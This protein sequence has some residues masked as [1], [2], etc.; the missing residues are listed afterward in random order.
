MKRNFSIGIVLLAMGFLLLPGVRVSSS[1]KPKGI[2]PISA[3]AAQQRIAGHIKPAAAT[4]VVNTLMDTPDILPGDGLCSDASG[5][6][7]LRAAITEANALAGTDQIHFNILPINFPQTIT[8]TSALPV[9]SDIVIIDGTTQPGFSGAPIVEVRGN[10]PGPAL[11]EVSASNCTIRGLILNGKDGDGIRLEGSFNS[12]V[13]NYIGTDISGLM[14]GPGLGGS[15]IFITGSSFNVIGSIAPG[16]ANIIAFTGTGIS[17]ADGAFSSNGNFI[18]GNSMFSNSLLGID[19]DQNLV[20]PNDNCDGD[21][22]SDTDLNYPDL[23]GAQTTGG[24]ISIQGNYNSQSGS[25]EQLDFYVNTVCHPSGFGEGQTY[26]GTTVVVPDV[27]C[28][29]VFS[30]NFPVA[31]AAGKFITAIARDEAN[32]SS[33][34]SACV[35]V[36]GSSCLIVCPPNQIRNT[37]PNQCGAVVTYPPPTTSGSCGA[38]TPACNPA[39]GSFFPRGSTTVSCSAVG[40]TGCSFTINVIDNSPPRITCPENIVAATD[41]ERANAVVGYPFATVSDN[42]PGTAAVCLPPSGAVFPLGASSVVCSAQDAAGNAVLCSFIVTVVDSQTPIIRCPANLAIVPPTGQTSAVVTYPAPSVSDNLPGV[43]VA[44]APVSG[45]TF[46]AGTTTVTCTAVDASGNRA[47][48]S[49]TVAVGGPQL[50]TTIP[51]STP[52][53]PIATASPARKAPKPKNSLCSLFT[54]QNIGFA[55]LVLTYDSITRTGTDVDNKRITD[56]NDTTFFSVSLLNADQSLASLNIGA[57]LTLQPNQS[58]TLCVKF[59]ALIPAL[60]GKTSGLAASSVLPDT[61]TS[62]INFRQNAGANVAIP[63]LA[64]VTT[65]VVLIDPTNPRRP[66]VVSFSRDGD[67]ITTSCA[68]Y[69]SNLDVNHAKY[70]FLNASGQVVAGPFE[71][72]LTEPVRS[73]NLVKGQSF[74]IEQRFTG[75]SSSPD[76]TSVRITVSDGGSSAVASS[77]TAAAPSLSP[78]SIQL[79]RQAGS[80]TLY[81]P[82][83]RLEPRH[84]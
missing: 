49:F 59:A 25:S 78:S 9:I 35:P 16:D 67:N 46:P 29:A 50:K 70:E 38:V 7:S 39:S 61:I 36:I 69:D 33:E 75:A 45:S 1:T 73:Q 51:G 14:P 65:G 81:L 52:A 55:P 28:N 8:L 18:Q 74:S 43:T 30:V 60:A 22:G 53:V 62:N 40:A 6:C 63:V 11:L 10:V 54:V 79:I 76:A 83:V 24:T 68:V 31:V 84:P 23:T 72:D 80:V 20:T 19:L 64:H 41:P 21:T 27:T 66:P 34:F 44:C 47:S 3:R 37:D 12:V 71:V 77:S 2:A 13:G 42:C 82:D 48:C 15:G 57:V 4:F 17:I 58:Q 56:P 32:N 5:N 26:I